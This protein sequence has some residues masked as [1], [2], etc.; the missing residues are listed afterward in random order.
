MLKQQALIASSL[1]IIWTVVEIFGRFFLEQILKTLVFPIFFF[2]K[3]LAAGLCL[4]FQ[5]SHMI[6][7]FLSSLKWRRPK[8]QSRSSYLPSSWIRNRGHM[9]PLLGGILFVAI[10]VASYALP[11]YDGL[12]FVD[13]FTMAQRRNSKTLKLRSLA[14]TTTCL[15]LFQNLPEFYNSNS[16][17]ILIDSSTVVKFSVLSG[18]KNPIH[19]DEEIG[20]ESLFGRRVP[21][22]MLYQAYVLTHL[23]RLLVDHKNW[24]LK[25]FDVEFKKPGYIYDESQTEK[26]ENMPIVELR[27]DP[28]IQNA[29]SDKLSGSA[30]ITQRMDSSAETTLADDRK[31]DFL[32]KYNFELEKINSDSQLDSHLNVSANQADY[33]AA[34]NNE[35]SK[36]LEAVDVGATFSSIGKI[37]KDWLPF[38]S[39]LNQKM[40][41]SERQNIRPQGTESEDS[42]STISV[43]QIVSGMLSG[44]LVNTLNKTGVYSAQTLNFT[45]LKI[46]PTENLEFRFKIL[47]TKKY[48][49]T[50]QLKL[51]IETMVLNQ[52]GELVATGEATVV[53]PMNEQSLID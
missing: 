14:S 29:S 13:S 5:F 30:Q 15:N 26:N 34:P 33:A 16:T 39:N 17:N 46:H 51:T 2:F 43:A 53:T 48:P 38:L 18:D 4:A 9:T 25:R 19:L 10:F 7:L 11:D 35:V 21:H 20:K 27:I 47:T 8:T 1:A 49:K 12:I 24:R 42:L 44:A 40:A 22:G 3:L 41:T 6:S 50:H 37:S 36:Q 32:F 23:E 45:G 28:L 52:K 31:T